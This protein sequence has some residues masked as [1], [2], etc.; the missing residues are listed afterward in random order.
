MTG[1]DEFFK[2]MVLG[3]LGW[4]AAYIAVYGTA[5][6]WYRSPVGRALII[7]AVGLAMMLTYSVL[8]YFLG[9]DYAG[10]DTLRIVG[11]SV[12]FFGLAYAF[13]AMIRELR[14][15][16]RERLTTDRDVR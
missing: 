9:P 6:R 12:L 11:I 2:W 4:D 1:V 16:Q 13:V 10:R 8:F 15:G 3:C 14:R 7:K 5:T